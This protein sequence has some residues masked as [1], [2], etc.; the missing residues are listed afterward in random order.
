MIQRR[1]TFTRACRDGQYGR[2]C[3]Q[4]ELDGVFVKCWSY[5][6]KVLWVQFESEEKEREWMTKVGLI[7]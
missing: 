1:I 5:V 2:I 7:R 6:H 3:E 4:A